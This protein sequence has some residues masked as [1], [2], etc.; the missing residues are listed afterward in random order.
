MLIG[1]TSR[2]SGSIGLTMFEGSGIL[3]IMKY[4]KLG[5]SDMEVSVLSLGTWQLVD[6]RIR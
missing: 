6:S 5:V 2:A 4:R 1:V 3:I